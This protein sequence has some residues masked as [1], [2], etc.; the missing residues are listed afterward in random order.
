VNANPSPEVFSVEYCTVLCEGYIMRIVAFV[1][2]LV[3]LAGGCAST[4]RPQ[5]PGRVSFVLDGPGFSLYKDGVKYGAGGLSSAP[6]QAVAGNPTA[7]EHARKFVSRSRLFWSLYALGV[8]CLITSVAVYPGDRG[9]ENRR[10]LGA[11]F[12]FAGLGL[13][14][15]SLVAA[16]TAPG[17][18]YDAV[19]IYN[20]GLAA[21]RK[22]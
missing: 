19:N 15:T 22:P 7:E 2:A 14:T 3:F 21:N 16:F 11:G 6:V 12:G 1:T 9:H 20:D 8:G 4:Y 5:E 17:H 13:L 18:L 10:E